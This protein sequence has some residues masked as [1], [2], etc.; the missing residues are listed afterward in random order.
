MSAV[1]AIRNIG[2]IAHIDAGKTTLTERMLFYSRKIHRMGEVHDGTATMDYMP[3][4]QERGITI[5]SACTTCTWK[6][7]SINVV[8]TPGHVDFTMEVERSLR[9]LDG[10]VGVFCAVGGVEP[11]SETVWRQSERFGVPK[12]AF[13]NKMDRTGADFSATLDAMRERLGANPLPV[14]IPVGAADSFSGVIDLV[15]QTILTFAPEDQGQTVR[16]CPLENRPELVSLAQKWRERMLE[17]LAENDDLFM[18]QYFENTFTPQEIRAA[19]R[20]ATIAR[21]I[22]PVLSGSALKNAGVQPLLDAVAAYL[23]SPADLPPVRAHAGEGENAPLVPC[24]VS[25]PLAGLVFKV[26]LDGGRKLAFV[27]LYSGTAKEGD[28]CFNATRNANERISRLYRLHADRREQLAE[29]QAGDIVAM[30][31]L[32]SATTGDTITAPA[33]PLLLESITA[34]QPVIN[35]ALEPRNADEGKILDEALERFCLEDPTLR[36]ELDEGSGHRIVSG[37]GELHL[38]VILERI[39]REYGIA[40]R[41]GHPQVVRRETPSREASAEAVFDRELGKL[42]HHGQV[43]VR[44]RP[45]ARGMGNSVD[46]AVDESLF[47]AALRDA[48]REGVENALQSGP[49]TGYPLQDVAVTVASM[50]RKE[51]QSTPIGFHMAAGMAVRQALEAAGIVT[52]EPLMLVEISV[53]ENVLG[54]AIALFSAKGGKV[55]NLADRAGMKLVQ[56]LAP[57]SQ[58]FGFSTEL[59]S[60]TQ[61]RAGLVVRFERFDN[62]SL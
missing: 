33:H 28:V 51:G 37:M 41:S 38:D 25:A 36:T 2:I 49:L 17:T 47:P 59:R 57:L 12:L 11:Q 35:M 5:M 15:G 16:A 6:G 23:P 43:G 54:S 27:R 53:P 18:E 44:I 39:H 13:I 42:M 1:S 3:E 60:A 31:G 20:R 8:D 32:R 30:I 34:Y 50:T 62:P 48:V 52:L 45:L 40:P 58:L 61:G 10:A 55:D 46:F 24:D 21:K 26:L 19:V 22:T 7:H 4:E 29:A 56:G 9:V 14:I